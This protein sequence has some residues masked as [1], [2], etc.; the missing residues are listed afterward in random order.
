MP[1]GKPW[2]IEEELALKQ[3]VTA[4][5]PLETIAERLGKPCEA[6]RQKIRRLGLEVVEQSRSVCSTT[7]KLSLPKELPSIEEALKLLAGALKRASQAGLDK[8]EVQRLQVIATLA[9]TYKEALA[10]Y[11]NYR[12]I[13]RRLIDLEAKYARLCEEKTKKTYAKPSVA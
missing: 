2:N 3:L 12:E 13:E 5:H 4:G 1:K 8:V 6:V 10:D 11:I 9:R 7:S